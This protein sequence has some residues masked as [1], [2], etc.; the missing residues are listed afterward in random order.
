M[1]GLEVILGQQLTGLLDP[2][3]TFLLIA[4]ISKKREVCGIFLRFSLT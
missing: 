1:A 3:V 4:M 2:P